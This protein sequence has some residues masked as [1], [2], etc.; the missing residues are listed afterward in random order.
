MIFVR[1]K[2]SKLLNAPVA[3]V[4][5]HTSKSVEL[6]VYQIVTDNFIITM[7]DNFHDWKIS[8]STINNLPESFY[9]LVKNLISEGI[10]ENIHYYYFEGFRREWIYS[11]LHLIKKEDVTVIEKTIFN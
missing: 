8:V 4:S 11:K 9:I 5:N 1:D 6:P 7:R 3:V 2:I 10:E